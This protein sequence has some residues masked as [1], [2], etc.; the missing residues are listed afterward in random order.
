MGR[1]GR[2][3][4]RAGRIVGT[5]ADWAGIAGAGLVLVLGF[6]SYLQGRGPVLLVV[7]LLVLSLNLFTFGPRQRQRRE[8][9][10]RAAER[11]RQER[12]PEH[13]NAEG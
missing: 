11:R 3:A 8:A 12:E 10:E 2:A 6:V 1:K 9:R 5:Y 13:E 4:E 7:G